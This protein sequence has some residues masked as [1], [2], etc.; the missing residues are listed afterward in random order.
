MKHDPQYAAFLRGINVGGHS[1]I[2]MAD[3]KKA[4]ETMGFTDVRTVLASGNVLFTS[5]QADDRTL[6][7]DIEAMLKK[8][9][10][11]DAGVML[12]SMEDIQGLA[13]S[14][15]FKR[16]KETPDIKLYVTFLPGKTKP[17]SIQ[18]PFA[19]PGFKIISATPTEVFS[20]VDLSQ[21]NGTT[22]AMGMIEK[23]YGSSVTTRNW[24]TVLKILG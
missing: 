1:L 13:A 10:K 21:G 14:N 15:P 3:L 6:T 8:V 20:V 18:I 9:L 23:E 11:K 16:I 22:G 12:R 17:R 24:N 19:I 2:R 5:A 7:R 4:F